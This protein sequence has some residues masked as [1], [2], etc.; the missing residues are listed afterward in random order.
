M[1]TYLRQGRLLAMLC[2]LATFAPALL[3]TSSAQAVCAP[4]FGSGSSVQALAQNKWIGSVAAAKCEGAAFPAVKY[5]GTAAGQVVEE[6]GGTT[7]ALEPA[8]NG[9][10]AEPKRLDGFIGVEPPTA[11][12]IKNMDEA[13]KGTANNGILT[14]PNAQEALAQI[15]TLPVSCTIKGAK[16]EIKT[17]NKPLAEVWQHGGAPETFATWLNFEAAEQ[18][19]GTGCTANPKLYVRSKTALTTLVEKTYLNHFSANFTVDNKVSWPAGDTKENTFSGTP[20][21]TYGAPPTTCTAAAPKAP[22]EGNETDP[23]LVE[24]VYGEPGTTGYVGLADAEATNPATGKPWFTVAPVTHTIECSTF[25]FTVV[26]FILVLQ[27][28]GTVGKL[29]AKFAS[30]V[31]SGGTESNCALAKYSGEPAKNE[32]N[33]S[34]SAVTQENWKGGEGYTKCFLTYDLAWQHYND[35]NLKEGYSQ[36]GATPETTEH[37]VSAYQKFILG[38]AAGEGQTLLNTSFYTKLPAGTLAKAIEG[39]ALIGL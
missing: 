1:K 4:I 19:E 37:T 29:T 8:K 14:I 35:A 22:A 2:A 5:L 36:G 31:G 27:N 11:A 17:Y 13:G 20:D 26:S 6:W 24:N 16:T 12:T 10:A 21:K 18:V 28:N 39:Q 23:K 25:K 30:P 33:T 9:V 7:K 38:T 32:A 34:W 3:S 15:V